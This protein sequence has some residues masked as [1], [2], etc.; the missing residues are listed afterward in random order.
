VGR[1]SEEPHIFHA[2]SENPSD[3]WFRGLPPPPPPPKSVEPRPT[4]RFRV[5]TALNSSNPAKTFVAST[6][7]E[8]VR[9]V[10]A[11]RGWTEAANSK[12]SAFAFKWLI[13]DHDYDY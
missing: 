7:L 4:R 1:A 13:E 3:R 6:K 10:F 11:R 5:A 2:Y 8:Y 9:R 12:T